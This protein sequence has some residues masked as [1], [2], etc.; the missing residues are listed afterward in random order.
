MDE[1]FNK[2]GVS[3]TS[4]CKMRNTISQK[5]KAV[6]FHRLH[7]A[8]KMLILPNIWDPLGALLLESLEYPAIATA[9]A[10]IAYSNGYHDGENISFNDMLTSVTK[11]THSVHLPVT[12][13]IESGYAADDIQLQENI[14]LLIKAGI[15]G[16][17]ME[18][19]DKKTNT[20]IS[21]ESQCSKINLIRKTADE[22][23]ISL[24][25]NARTDV[26]VHE[27]SFASEEAKLDEAITRG[28]AYKEAGADGFYPITLTQEQ[29]IKEIIDQVKQPLNILTIPGIPDLKTLH[30]IGVARVSLG[31][32]F[33]KIAIRA[34]KEMAIQLKDGEGL[35]VIT[36]NEITSDYLKSLVNKD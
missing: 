10:S 15:V 28:L 14:K 34:M 16:I 36:G 30:K 27:K 20:L 1:T 18:D 4:S 22:M 19:T 29:Q 23:G 9:S 12:A 2:T 32:S 21:I 11:I 26:Y 17:N 24:F 35:S 13:D 3:L 8:G 7:H 5:E 6:E 31:P 25:I 33:L